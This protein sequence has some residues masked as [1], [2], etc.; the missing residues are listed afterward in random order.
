MKIIDYTVVCMVCPGNI[1]MQTV[2]RAELVREKIADGWQPLGS[3]VILKDNGLYGLSG[4]TLVQAMVRYEQPAA[5]TA[6]SEGTTLVSKE[7]QVALLAEHRH[8]QAENK[9]LRNQ[10]ERNILRSAEPE[11]KRLREAVEWACS[12]G[13]LHPLSSVDR[14]FRDE[15]RR[16]AG[17]ESSMP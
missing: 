8:L 9:H 4:N 12:P 3:P 15:L 17:L 16:R 11:N 7:D 2:R 6:S 13:N 5:T 10:V 1:A 14:A